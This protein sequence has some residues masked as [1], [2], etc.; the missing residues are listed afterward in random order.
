[1]LD[2]GHPKETPYRSHPVGDCN[3]IARI[4]RQKENGLLEVITGAHP[5]LL[6]GV[7]P[8]G[9]AFRRCAR[10]DIDNERGYGN[11]RSVGDDSERSLEGVL[12]AECDDRQTHSVGYDAS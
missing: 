6:G 11:P 7:D 10:I 2:T 12:L 5:H 1:M 8:A 3:P 4:F 9:H